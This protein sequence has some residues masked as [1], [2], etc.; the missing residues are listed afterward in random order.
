MTKQPVYDASERP[1]DPVS[2]AIYRLPGAIQEDVQRLLGLHAG[3]VMHAHEPEVF[4]DDEA[5]LAAVTLVDAYE[6]ALRVISEAFDEPDLAIGG[7]REDDEPECF[8]GSLNIDAGSLVPEF[9]PFL[10]AQLDR[11]ADAMREKYSR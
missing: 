11:R 8:D 4:N 3:A 10:R 1:A 7:N 2:S 9:P 5:V 6:A